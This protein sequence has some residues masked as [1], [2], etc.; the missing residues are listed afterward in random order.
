MST[1]SIE[2]VLA[3]TMVASIA[4]P[5]HLMVTMDFAPNR[6]FTP[7]TMIYFKAIMQSHSASSMQQVIA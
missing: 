6:Y 2:A 1:I 5:A 7:L 4:V 3:N